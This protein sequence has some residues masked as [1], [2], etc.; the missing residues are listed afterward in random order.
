MGYKKLFT[1]L[2]QKM[3]Y[4][5]SAS[6]IEQGVKKLKVSQNIKVQLYYIV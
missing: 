5:L 2:L 3:I 1:T 4:T 6:Y